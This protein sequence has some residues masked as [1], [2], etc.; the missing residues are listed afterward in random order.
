VGDPVYGKGGGQTLLHAAELT[1][2]RA[3]KEPIV[4]KAPLP[5]RFLA[6]GFSEG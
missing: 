1:I 5:E 4:A 2:P 6:A 3:G